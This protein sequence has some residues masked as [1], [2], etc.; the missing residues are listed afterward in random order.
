MYF[1]RG[2]TVVKDLGSVNFLDLFWSIPPVFHT[3][4]FVSKGECKKFWNRRKEE[5]DKLVLQ[6]LELKG[7]LVDYKYL[8][9]FDTIVEY[10]DRSNWLR[11]V[12]SNHEPW[13]YFMDY[14]FTVQIV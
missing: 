13:S 2:V 1:E 3:L 12:D 14:L 9:P 7:S 5:I 10:A 8:K 4:Y 6:N 11:G